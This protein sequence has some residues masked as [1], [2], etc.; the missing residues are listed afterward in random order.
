MSTRRTAISLAFVGLTVGAAFATVY[1]VGP[2]TPQ[3][4]AYLN[5]A[6][7]VL[8]V[9][10]SAASIGYGDSLRSFAAERDR[11]ATNQP[12]VKGRFPP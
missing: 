4:S 11:G 9:L 1:L 7:G 8:V 12:G 3:Q 5:V 6:F 2:I 10:A